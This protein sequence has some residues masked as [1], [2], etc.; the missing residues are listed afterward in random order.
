MR[1]KEVVMARL[2]NLIKK[3]NLLNNTTMQCQG[4]GG[5]G[6]TTLQPLGSD[7]DPRDPD[8]ND[9]CL[10]NHNCAGC[11]AICDDREITLDLNF[12]GCPKDN[13]KSKV[14]HWCHGK[15][16]LKH[17]LTSSYY[18]CERCGK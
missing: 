14:C 17:L 2:I 10:N 16:I 1:D 15:T 7:P 11:T 4:C 12:T 5:G 6:C 13:S 18:F 9:P 8:P 3:I